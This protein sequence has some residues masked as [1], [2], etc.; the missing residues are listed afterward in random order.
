[1]ALSTTS[2]VA[3]GVPAS[4]NATILSMQ[5]NFGHMR[6]EL[7]NVATAVN[8]AGTQGPQ[9]PQGARGAQG[10]QGSQGAVGVQGTAGASPVGNQGPQGPQGSGGGAGGTQPA[11]AHYPNQPGSAVRGELWINAALRLHIHTGAG[12]SAIL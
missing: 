1:M 6:T 12:W 9:G 8:A 7:Q 4:P 2:N 10:A 3:A 5:Q 11:V